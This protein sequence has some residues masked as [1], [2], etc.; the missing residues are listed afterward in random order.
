M[1]IYKPAYPRAR[2]TYTTLLLVFVFLD[3]KR[4][5]RCSYRKSLKNHLYKSLFSINKPNQNLVSFTCSHSVGGLGTCGG[6]RGYGFVLFTME[7]CVRSS[8]VF[9]IETIWR[10]VS[11]YR[12]DFTC[13]TN[14]Y[15]ND[16]EP[17]EQ[18]NTFS[19]P[20]FRIFLK[21]HLII[22]S[23][24]SWILDWPCIHDISE[25]MIRWHFSII[26]NLG[27]RTCWAG[28]LVSLPP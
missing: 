18:V 22:D 25:L 5:V 4:N 11:L 17:V 15:R 26:L 10:N 13:V 12:I 1:I 21:W 24:I 3:R 28:R 2:M 6:S 7:V 14:L 27:L 9:C 23:L 8:M 16:R 20:K 19:G